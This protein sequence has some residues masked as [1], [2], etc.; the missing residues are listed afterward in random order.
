MLEPLRRL[1]QDVSTAENLD[2]ALP[3][4]VHQVREALE[5]DACAVFLRDDASGEMVL[6]ATE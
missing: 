5:V 1:V 4:I 3:L 2:E 6:M